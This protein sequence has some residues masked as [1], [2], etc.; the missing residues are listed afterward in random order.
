MRNSHACAS[1]HHLRIIFMLRSLYSLVSFPIVNVFQF[2]VIYG[3]II[4]SEGM[5][6]LI[7]GRCEP[8]DFTAV[9]TERTLVLHLGVR[10]FSSFYKELWTSKGSFRLISFMSTSSYTMPF[11]ILKMRVMVS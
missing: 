5:A 6:V 3:A 2:K 7:G 4:V 1:H 11:F 10:D 8:G 9:G